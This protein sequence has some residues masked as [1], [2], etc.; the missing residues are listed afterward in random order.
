MNAELTNTDGRQIP[1]GIS[2]PG[3][4]TALSAWFEVRPTD[5]SDKAVRAPVG[6]ACAG[7]R[8]S[9]RTGRASGGLQHAF[10]LIE[11][12]GVLAVMAILAAV[13]V[14]ALIRQMDK[15]AG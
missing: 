12:V 13:L 6:S 2:R 5:C 1:S 8:T 3:A 15:I 10:S 9:R 4:R 14:P 11:L 7:L